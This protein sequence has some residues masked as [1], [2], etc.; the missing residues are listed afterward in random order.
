MLR[1]DL[2]TMWHKRLPPSIQG[3][4]RTGKSLPCLAGSVAEEVQAVPECAQK[5]HDQKTGIPK[6][7]ERSRDAGPSLNVLVRL[8]CSLPRCG[9]RCNLQLQ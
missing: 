5:R 6:H 1:I 3:L 7:Q 8:Q 4:R 2:L 9:G